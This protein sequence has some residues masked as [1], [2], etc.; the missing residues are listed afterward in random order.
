MAITKKQSEGEQVFEETTKQDDLVET[1][2][3]DRIDRQLEDI[4]TQIERLEARKAKLEKRKTDS[5]ALE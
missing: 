2:T 3:I 1:F 5:L 4:N